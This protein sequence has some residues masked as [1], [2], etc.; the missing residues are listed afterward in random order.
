MAVWKG[1]KPTKRD[2]AGNKG[3]WMATYRGRLM[4][5]NAV[6]R[7]VQHPG[8]KPRPFLGPGLRE[9][10]K[11]LKALVKKAMQAKGKTPASLSKRLSV[12]VVQAAGVVRSVAAKLCPVDTGTLKNSIH[13]TKVSEFKCLVGTN[14]KYGRFMEFGTKPHEIRPVKAKALAFYW[15]KLPPKKGWTTLRTG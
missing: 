14:V 4:P 6:F 13:V 7:S 9:G 11:T 12:A 5:I 1:R 2:Q 15:P 3:R 8:T 10:V